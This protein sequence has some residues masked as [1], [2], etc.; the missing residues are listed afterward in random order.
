MAKIAP[1]ITAENQHQYREQVERVSQFANH[2]HLDIMDGKFAPT[3]TFDL[4]LLWLPDNVT[5]DVHI[6]YQEPEQTIEELSKLNVRTFIVH[7][8]ADYDLKRAVKRVK[9]S[10]CK[11]G[12]S[13]L[14]ETSVE[15]AQE[16]IAVADHVL[17]F[18]GNLGYQGGSTADMELLK[19]VEEVKAINSQVEIGWDGGVNLENIKQIAE[20]GVDVINVGGAIHFARDPAQAYRDLQQALVR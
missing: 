13:L 7:A 18:S 6:M 3:D 20:A 14:A 16:A 4:E 1:T 19:K 9:D 15:S 12:I 11:F 8:E 17:I 10:N 2:L 5:C